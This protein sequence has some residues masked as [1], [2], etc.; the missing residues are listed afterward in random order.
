MYR[1]AKQSLSMQLTEQ[2]CHPRPLLV[3]QRPVSQVNVILPDRIRF[4]Y[5]D[6]DGRVGLH[7]VTVH[8]LGENA[9][10]VCFLTGV[11][12]AVITAENKLDVNAGADFAGGIQSDT[13]VKAN[14]E[15]AVADAFRMDLIASP[16]TRLENGE[17]MTR[18]DWE[19]RVRRRFALDCKTDALPLSSMLITVKSGIAVTLD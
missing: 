4:F 15:F 1:I 6:A 11:C 12:H 5:P 18:Q 16:V 7:E 14:A 3:L 17:R 19:R 8:T 9:H 2:L 13:E 10:G